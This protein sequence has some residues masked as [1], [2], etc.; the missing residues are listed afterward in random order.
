MLVLLETQ[1][2]RSHALYL[3]TEYVDL[4]VEQRVLRLLC[5][6]GT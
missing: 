1:S 3:F 4:V 2:P 5:I 6:A